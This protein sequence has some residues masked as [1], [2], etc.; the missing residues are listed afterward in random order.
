MAMRCEIRTQG[1]EEN[2][3]MHAD[4]FSALGAKGSTRLS[5]LME[6]H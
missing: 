3:R 4:Q 1:R 6:I 5:L 2:E